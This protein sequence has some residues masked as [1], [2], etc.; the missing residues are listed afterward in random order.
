MKKKTKYIYTAICVFAAV[1][2]YLSRQE[3]LHEKEIEE[4]L[5]Y[6]LIYD[7]NRGYI[8]LI[9]QF[10]RSKSRRETFL[11][12]LSN[13]QKF[14]IYNFSFLQEGDSIYKP[15]RTDSLYIFT[16]EKEYQFYIKR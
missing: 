14:T 11:V 9:T 4:G 1:I 6:P 2:F 5:E 13:G 15:S 7:Y 3:Y 16:K 8:G 12:E 10:S